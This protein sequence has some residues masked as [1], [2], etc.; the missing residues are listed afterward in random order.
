MPK[1]R[2][3]AAA[4]LIA[5]AG[6]AN[7]IEIRDGKIALFQ[8]GGGLTLAFEPIDWPGGIDGVSLNV[9]GP[10]EFAAMIESGNEVPQMNLKDFG[11]IKDGVYSYEVRGFN[12]DRVETKNEI[13]N[14]RD[15]P[16]VM[17]FG[18]FSLSGN[19]YVLKGEIVKFDQEAV[20]K[21]KP[22]KPADTRPIDDRDKA[23]DNS[24]LKDR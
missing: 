16:T 8:T 2:F 13:N 17:E 22:E 19:I 6:S 4:L 3:T 14:G 1:F 12:G 5:A 18:T 24:E 20:D 10:G 23:K 9:D 15:K 7:A 21:T 11:E